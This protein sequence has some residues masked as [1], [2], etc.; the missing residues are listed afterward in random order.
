MH[1]YIKTALI[2]M[3]NRVGAN[4]E[5]IDFMEHNWFMKYSWTKEQEED[6]IKWLTK[7]LA[8]NK[9]RAEFV[10]FPRITKPK[11]AAETFVWYCGWKVEP[12]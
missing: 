11:K 8:P 12:D 10:A 9:I 5:D 3:C 6:Y 2:E 7:Y 4:H 1:E